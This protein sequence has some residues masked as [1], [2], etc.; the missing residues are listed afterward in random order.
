M[1]ALARDRVSLADVKILVVEDFQLIRDM[2][3]ITCGNIIRGAEARGATTGREAVNAT[4]EFQPDVIFLDLALPD[5]DGLDFLPEIFA[6]CRSAKVIA[7]TSHVDEFTLHRAL[8]A[9]VHGFVDKNEQPLP[10]LQEAIQT[11]TSGRHYFS[12]TAH[13]LRMAMRADP[14]EFSKL[15]SAHEQKLL[16]YFGEGLSNEDIAARTGLAWGTIRNHRNNI[17]A[18]LNLHSTPELMRY[19]IEKGF[20]RPRRALTPAH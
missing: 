19:A 5:G 12:S 6:A 20:T 11:V 13:R 1:L 8:Q 7:L 18:K 16:G 10:V 2:L 9:N 15:L 4:R 3:V 17:M 14:A